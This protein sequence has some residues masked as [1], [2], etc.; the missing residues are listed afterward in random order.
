MLTEPLQGLE[1]NDVTL[2]PFNR[3]IFIFEETT[4]P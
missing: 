3:S 1:L 2:N 4:C